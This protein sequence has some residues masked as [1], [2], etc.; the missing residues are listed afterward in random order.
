MTR[1]RITPQRVG[2]VVAVALTMLLAGGAR[3][4][5][6]GRTSVMHTVK[7][8]DTLMLLAAE[9]YGD[10]SQAV[11]IMA[12]NRLDHS[13]PLKPG[14]RIRIPQAREITAQIG[15]S[16]EALAAT[17]LGDKRRGRFL[18]GWA[19][20]KPNASIP[21]GATIRIPFHIKHTARSKVSLASLAATYL[22]SSQK[23]LLLREY[24]F[25]PRGTQTLEAGKTIV[26]PIQRV[27]VRESKRPPRDRESQS[28]MARRK[29]MQRLADRAYPAA[30][31]AW[32]IGKYGEVK[33]LLAGID[34][35]FL[36]AED[37][38]RI[39][40]L[41]GSAYIAFSDTDT[42]L[43]TF[44]RVLE[45]NGSHKL[46]DYHYSPTIRAVWKRAGGAIET[47]RK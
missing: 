43:A 24:N 20:M 32:K 35:D 2:A 4:Q 17:Y 29:K 19:R 12:V 14:E 1:V 39:G 42:A 9:Y 7:A 30:S 15:D 46:D 36:D 18:A 41:L 6:A 28:R 22:G 33:R 10:R 23:A 25:L 38:V 16:F 31:A 13:R 27:T 37:A 11:F 44:T 40:V 8:G 3:A 34:L 45:R 21:A 26:I 47:R 5:Q